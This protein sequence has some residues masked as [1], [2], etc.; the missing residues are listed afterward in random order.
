MSLFRLPGG[1]GVALLVLW[2]GQQVDA[3][4]GVAVDCQYVAFEVQFRYVQYGAACGIRERGIGVWATQV[5]EVEEPGAACGIDH[6]VRMLAGGV[7]RGSR[8]VVKEELG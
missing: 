1:S 7:V 3:G 5:S 2:R 8:T 4:R 6:N